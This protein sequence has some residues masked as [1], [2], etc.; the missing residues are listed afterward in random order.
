MCVV[1]AVLDVTTSGF[2]S[3]SPRKMHES[4]LDLYRTR[5]SLQITTTST[6][7]AQELAVAGKLRS[8]FA[9]D[10]PCFDDV[11]ARLPEAMK[12]LGEAFIAQPADEGFGEPALPGLAR[13]DVVTLAHKA[14][15][16]EQAV[17][18]GRQALAG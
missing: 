14:E 9:V 11:V 13:C 10:T 3:F 12:M 6:T 16:G 8:Q 1:A 15:A 4:V 5:F 7:A 18:D 17:D 2:R